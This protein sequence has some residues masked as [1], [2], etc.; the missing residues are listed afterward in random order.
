MLVKRI[1]GHA[2]MSMRVAGNGRGLL[3][4]SITNSRIQFEGRV[5]VDDLGLAP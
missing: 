1:S 5:A 4:S 3:V 2:F